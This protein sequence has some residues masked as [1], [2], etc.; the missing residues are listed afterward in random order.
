MCTEVTTC[1][2]LGVCPDLVY[3]VID[4]YRSL[5]LL[6]W[7]E[8][9]I[10]R[11]GRSLITNLKQFLVPAM[12]GRSFLLCKPFSNF[13]FM[14][15]QKIT[16]KTHFCGKYIMHQLRFHFLCHTCSQLIRGTHCPG[17]T[18]HLLIFPCRA[19]VRWR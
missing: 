13:I 11:N 5:S 3:V 2:V 18:N 15:F 1:L 7:K 12:G 14:M 10:R 19:A 4:W 16:K 6:L 17:N 8:T 9:M